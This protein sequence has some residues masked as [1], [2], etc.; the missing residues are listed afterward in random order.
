M[1]ALRFKSAAARLQAQRPSRLMVMNAVLVAAGGALGALLRWSLA[2]HADAQG[3]PWGTLV[4]NLIGSLLL[5]VL[6]VL[7]AESVLSREQALLFGTGLLGAFTTMSTFAVELVRLMDA[8]EAG[9]AAVYLAVTVVG[10]P[11]LAWAGWAATANA[12]P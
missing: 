8:G 5:G 11:L 12:M 10:C 3:L 7:L 9:V 1:P 4:V 2:P 6:T